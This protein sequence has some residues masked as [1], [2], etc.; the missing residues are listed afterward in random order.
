MH[1]L[2][3]HIIAPLVVITLLLTGAVA[4]Y[5]LSTAERA[6]LDQA[7]RNA[8]LLAKALDAGIQSEADLTQEA[9]QARI[10]GLTNATSDIQEFNVL[11]LEGSGSAIVA[12]N[13]PGN[14]EET[15]PDEHEALLDVLH[16]GRP[17]VIIGQEEAEKVPRT[18]EPTPL[19][20]TEIQGL[21]DPAWT[22][23]PPRY[24]SLFAPIH[25]AG[26]P[27]GAINV[28]FVLVEVEAGLR[29][30]RMT[31]FGVAA[32]EA[33]G[34]VLVAGFLLNRHALGP[35]LHLKTATRAVT[36]G[37]LTVR[38]PLARQDE[39]GDLTADFNAMTAALGAKA[40][41]I[42]ALEQLRDDLTHMIV[43]DM[44]NPLQ[45]ISGYGNLLQ[46]G[47]MGELSSLQVNAVSGIQRASG[48]L[49]N[50]V[51]N[52][53]DI[54]RLESGKVE[55]DLTPVDLGE[56][57][58]EAVESVRLLAEV[59][60]QTIR[61]ELAKGLPPLPADRDLVRRVLVNLLSNALKH[62]EPGNVVTLQACAQ[63]DHVALRVKDQGEGIAPGDQARI[64]EK[65]TQATDRSRG[66][67]TDTG[68]GL[69]FCKLAVQA[70]GGSINVESEGVPGR[71]SVFTVQ[72]PWN[73]TAGSMTE[74][75]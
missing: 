56:V 3:F 27:V 35:L 73:R 26:Q 19:P 66:S 49:S 36:A 13:D 64:F 5:N 75:S 70:H 72:L 47:R 9:L 71:G 43:H 18:P 31:F 59:Q 42:A 23:R 38:I 28:K 65:F 11:L 53:L 30:M 25:V 58:G 62:S 15:S 41:E 50:M 67:K 37:D 44:K 7:Q 57:S 33:L 16:H 74:F 63:G 55:L 1:S 22:G 12:S 29:Q 2:C 60:E 69:A 20:G 48:T 4:L 52:L 32:L 8:A 24:V 45:V 40:Q 6:E 17:V 68:L 46:D 39:I 51:F 21:S 10:S 14:L 61:V 54:G 34:I